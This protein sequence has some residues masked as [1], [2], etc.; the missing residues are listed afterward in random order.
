[1]NSLDTYRVRFPEIFIHDKSVSI[2]SYTKP[3]KYDKSASQN[4]EKFVKGV[5]WSRYREDRF[6]PKKE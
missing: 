3:K 1:M 6:R 2:L 5:V 4:I